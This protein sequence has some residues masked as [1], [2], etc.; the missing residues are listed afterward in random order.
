MYG[1]KNLLFIGEYIV[2]FFLNIIYVE[3]INIIVWMIKVF[4]IYRLFFSFEFMVIYRYVIGWVVK[5][6]Y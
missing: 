6:V 1:D 3:I 2:G 4:Y 5:E